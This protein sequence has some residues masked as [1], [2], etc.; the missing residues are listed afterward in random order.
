MTVSDIFICS[1]YVE[2]VDKINCRRFYFDKGVN[3]V[4]GPNGCG[5]SILLEA[6]RFCLSDTEKSSI[7]SDKLTVEVSFKLSEDSIKSFRRVVD[8]ED[9]FVQPFQIDEKEVT[10]GE[11]YQELAVLNI[12]S[13]EIPY[14]IPNASWGELTTVSKTKLARL[15]E[16]IH[17]DGAD[18]RNEYKQKKNALE[19]FESKK[20]PTNGV[21]KPSKN[22]PQYKK[23]LE[24]FE[25]IE[26]ERQEF[27][28]ESLT[29][30]S[31]TLNKY[32]QLVYGNDNKKSVSLKPIDPFHAYLGVEFK[33]DHGYGDLESRGLS[34]GE[35]KLIS[36]AFYLAA[37]AA[38]KTPFVILDD[39]D[40]SLFEKTCEKVAPALEEVAASTGLQICVVCKYDK[41]KAGIAKKTD[42]SPQFLFC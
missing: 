11:Y 34:G 20:K 5:K 21:K 8:K 10:K 29:S 31:A 19:E 30:I 9:Y 6:M 1:V 33:V 39:F 23:L 3:A 14:M 41:M 17:P 16:N 25:K 26:S 4:I 42:M 28:I 38:A 22:S 12:Y 15:I 32:Y 37:Q 27:F 40:L 18:S 35:S 13:V 7:I 36:I 24:D 2:G